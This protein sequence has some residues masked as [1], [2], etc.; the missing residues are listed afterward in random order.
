MLLFTD[1]HTGQIG[2]SQANYTA[3]EG[4]E[5]VLVCIALLS[6]TGPLTGSALIGFSG[7]LEGLGAI[8]EV[9][10]TGAMVGQLLLCQNLTIQDDNIAEP[11]QVSMLF[12]FIEGPDFISYA[13]GGD[14]A[15]VIVIDNDGKLGIFA[16]AE[17]DC[18]QSEILHI[19]NSLRHLSTVKDLVYRYCTM[20]EIYSLLVCMCV[21]VPSN[22]HFGDLVLILASATIGFSQANYTAMEGGEAVL[23]CIVLLSRTGPPLTEFALIGFS[24]SQGSLGRFSAVG[25]VNFAG[26]MVGDPLLCQNLTIQEDNIAEPD[27]VSMLSAFIEGPGSI[28]YAPGGDEATVIVIDNDGRLGIKYKILL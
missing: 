28:S 7:P 18:S 19:N 13:P 3:M 6:Q 27:Q 26:V 11:D 21:C 22:N 9:N 12:A 8:R 2:F 5:P 23:V 20:L 10:F 15:T 14:E 1:S 17:F 25:E 4:G 24:V 16:I